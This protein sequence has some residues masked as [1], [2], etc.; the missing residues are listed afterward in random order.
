MERTGLRGHG[1]YLVLLVL[2]G[3]QGRGAVQG[4]MEGEGRLERQEQRVTGALM[5]YL[6]FQGTKD[7][8]EIGGNQDPKAH[9]E[10]LVTR[11]RMDLLDQEGNQENLG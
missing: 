11:V 1:G 3:N 4:R 9:T 7:T 6:A 5:D 8:E 2:M 10:S